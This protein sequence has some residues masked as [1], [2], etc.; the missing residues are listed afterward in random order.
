MTQDIES[1][2]EDNFPV[3]IFV[4]DSNKEKL[5]DLFTE[6]PDAFNYVLNIDSPTQV[7]HSEILRV[8]LSHFS[9]TTDE[10]DDIS[11]VSKGIGWKQLY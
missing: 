9:I 8:L 2:I 3:F 10:L 7:Q 4:A 6:N 11:N 5:D 1:I